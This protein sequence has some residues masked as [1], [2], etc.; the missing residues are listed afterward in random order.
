[1]AGLGLAVFAT[2]TFTPTQQFGYLMITILSVALAGD[3]L[4]LPAI[5]SGPIGK[6]FCVRRKAA[7]LVFPEASEESAPAFS[8]S[9]VPAP[10]DETPFIRRRDT[11]H[12]RS[13]PIP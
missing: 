12:R 8:L 7:A 11:P 13:S 3:L 5:L 9:G 1:I 10:A 4:I 6:V 2:S